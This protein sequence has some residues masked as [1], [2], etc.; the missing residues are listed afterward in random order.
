MGYV[1]AEVGL[2]TYFQNYHIVKNELPVLGSCFG[3]GNKTGLVYVFKII[4][5]DIPMF[6]ATNGKLSPRP[7]KLHC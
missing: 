4:F 2:P 7:F 6:S 5:Q 1:Q 3:C